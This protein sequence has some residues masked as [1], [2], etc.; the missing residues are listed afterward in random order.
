MPLSSPRLGGNASLLKSAC[1]GVYCVDVWYVYDLDIEANIFEVASTRTGKSMTCLSTA[2]MDWL[3][4]G[5]VTNLTGEVM[6]ARA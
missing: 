1:I 2:T 4:Q 3:F 5:C 6:G